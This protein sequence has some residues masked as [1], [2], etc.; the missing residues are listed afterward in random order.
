MPRLRRLHAGRTAPARAAGAGAARPSARSLAGC[1]ES[2]SSSR[3]VSS[4]MPRGRTE[5]ARL[6]HRETQP[7]EHRRDAGEQAVAIGRVDEQL[8][9]AAHRQRMHLDQRHRAVGTQDR[10]GLPRDLLGPVAQEAAARE[11]PP[12]PAR[13][14]PRRSPRPQQRQRVGRGIR[15]ALAVASRGSSTS[16]RKRIARGG[17]EIGQQPVL[18]G[19]PQPRTGADDVGH[20]QQVQPVRAARGRRPVRR[21]GAPRRDR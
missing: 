8:G 17:V 20:G 3:K 4:A 15:H 1:C 11:N 5:H 21:T 14:P 9:A 6:H 12:R 13:R 10:R 16:L 2:A 18:P 19:V 7:V